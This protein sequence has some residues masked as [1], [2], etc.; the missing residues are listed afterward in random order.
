MP[1]GCLWNDDFALSV[2]IHSLDE[3]W[4]TY[5]TFTTIII[6]ARIRIVNKSCFWPIKEDLCLI[7]AMELIELNTAITLFRCTP[8]LILGLYF[9]RSAWV[10]ILSYHSL[11]NQN[12]FVGGSLEC[13]GYAVYLHTWRK[14]WIGMIPK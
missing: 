10:W 8:T 6:K 13:G 11:M 2:H 9:D 4:S 1:R 5:L 14:I 3:K 7:Q 12:G